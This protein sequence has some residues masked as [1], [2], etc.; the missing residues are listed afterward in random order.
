MP[1]Q[2]D[3]PSIC[4]Q[5]GRANLPALKINMCADIVQAIRSRPDLT[6]SEIA[7]AFHVTAQTVK[8]YARRAGIFRGKGYRGSRK[9]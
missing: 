4:L 8:N 5:C 1:T 2:R 9:P 6:Y 3:I 7:A